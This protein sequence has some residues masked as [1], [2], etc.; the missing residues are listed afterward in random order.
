[1]PTINYTVTLNDSAHKKEVATEFPTPGSSA[2][3]RAVVIPPVGDDP[4]HVSTL[5]VAGTR[6][7][8]KDAQYSDHVADAIAYAYPTP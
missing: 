4:A 3:V 1:M 8:P 7:D 2:A 6:V 5:L